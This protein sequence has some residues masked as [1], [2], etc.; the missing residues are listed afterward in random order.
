MI[1][2]FLVIMTMTGAV[3]AKDGWQQREQPN[4]ETCIKRM[5]FFNETAREGRMA[6]CYSVKLDGK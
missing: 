3:E 1:K 2:V 5:A 6:L 4:L